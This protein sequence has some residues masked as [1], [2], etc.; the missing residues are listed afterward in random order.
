[1]A[2]LYPLPCLVMAETTIRIAHFI[3]PA[4]CFTIDPVRQRDRSSRIAQIIPQDFD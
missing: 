2:T 4:R 3:A 1:M